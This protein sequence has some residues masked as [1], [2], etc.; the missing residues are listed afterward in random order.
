[1]KL[2]TNILGLVFTLVFG[3]VILYYM[4]EVQDARFESLYSS[5]SSST[6]SS[7]PYSSPYSSY[8]SYSDSYSS[9]TEEAGV[10]CLFFFLFFLY[11]FIFNLVKVKTKTSK[12]ISIIGLSITGI[13]LLWDLLMI[14]DG[15]A[16]SFD[17][18]G[19]GFILFCMISLAFSI[20]GLV[21]CRVDARKQA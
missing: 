4:S 16:L 19:A 21:Q 18:V 17:E 13:F 2:A 15:G 3:I 14:G 20:V 8:S 9:L 5:L 11:Q 6:Y 10:I 7:Y 12:V 1:M